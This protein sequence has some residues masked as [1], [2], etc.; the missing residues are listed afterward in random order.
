MFRSVSRIHAAALARVGR[1]SDRGVPPA[2][3]RARLWP[4]RRGLGS[5]ATPSESSAAGAIGSVDTI[6][7]TPEEHMEMRRALK[8]LIDKEINPYVDQWEAENNFPAHE[9]MK[10]LG[11]AGFLGITRPTEYGGLGL[12]YTYSVA[13][14]EELGGITCGGV[15]GAVGIQTDMATPALARFGSDELKRNFLAPTIAG[16]MVACLGVSEPMAGS[17]VAN[18]KTRAEKKGD[19]YVINGSKTWIT[20]G[21]QADWICLLV[22]TGDGPS[23]KNKSLICVP[24]DSEGVTRGRRIDKLGMHCSDTAE[25]FFEDVRVP[26]SNVIGQEGAGFFYQMLQFQEERLFVGAGVLLPLDMMIA[27]TIEYTKNRKVFGKSVL[28]NQVVHFRLAELQTEVELLRSL[29]YRA[30]ALYVQGQD[31]TRLA[32]MVKLKAG[33]LVREVSDACLQYY[34]GMGF[35]SD[36]PISR[37]YRDTRI[38]S[39]AGGADEVMLGIISKYMGSLPK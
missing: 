33:R 15:P 20:N 4:S 9:V 8:K 6:Y 7:T 39:I 38:L 21:H 24:L 2:A 1:R 30:T 13:F 23:H 14:G 16:D 32:S 22:N 18:I 27:D 36:M 19:D 29:L 12:D 35:T 17:D 28:D 10:K 3:P 11:E 37:Y 31:V 26:Q 34:G 5:E 25:L